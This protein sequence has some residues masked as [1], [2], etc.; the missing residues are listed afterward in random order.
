VLHAFSGDAAMAARLV[1]V[2]YLVSFA[3]PVAFRSALGPRQA[4]RTLGDG[5]FVVET[6]APYLGPERERRNEPTTALRVVAELARIRGV[7]AEA[8]VAPIREAYTRLI[9]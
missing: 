9:G 6:D 4:A 3:L 7:E 8:L 1:E 2:G 5:T